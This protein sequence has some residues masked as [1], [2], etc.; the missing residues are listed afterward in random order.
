MNCVC[1]CENRV[2]ARPD[3]LDKVDYALNVTPVLENY[4]REEFDI[5]YPLDK[6]GK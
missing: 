3:R 5:T 4:L 2:W 6:L 1:F